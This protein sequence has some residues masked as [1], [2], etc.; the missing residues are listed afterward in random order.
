MSSGARDQTAAE[1]LAEIKYKLGFDHAIRRCEHEELLAWR[2]EQQ[3]WQYE[4]DRKLQRME[5]IAIFGACM[6]VCGLLATAFL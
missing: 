3:A 2:R 1:E 6:G 4:C 5:A